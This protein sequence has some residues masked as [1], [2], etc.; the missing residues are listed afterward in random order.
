MLQ[1]LLATNSIDIIARNFN[2]DLLKLSQNN[3]L[4]IFRDHVQMIN[5]PTNIP[6]SLINHVYIK[7]ALIEEF[8]TF[9]SCC[10]KN[11]S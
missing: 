4:D 8:F 7:R 1:S 9:T 6:G 5:K 11:C 10:S 2:Y 3:F